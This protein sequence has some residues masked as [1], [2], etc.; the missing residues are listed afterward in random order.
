MQSLHRVHT[1]GSLLLLL[2][3]CDRG[4]IATGNDSSA[5]NVV[6]A[7]APAGPDGAPAPGL[8][9]DAPSASDDYDGP[10]AIIDG[11]DYVPDALGPGPTPDAMR[12][13]EPKPDGQSECG[14]VGQACC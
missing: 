12:M 14:N 10:A 11:R 4:S 5:A 13:E 3:G 6:D 8:N 2:F 9:V 1:F 7:G